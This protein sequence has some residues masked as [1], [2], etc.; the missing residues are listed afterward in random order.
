MAFIGMG[1]RDEYLVTKVIK[2][3]FL[4][5]DKKGCIYCWSNISGKLLHTT[6]L[7]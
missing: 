2:D 1:R 4:A 5:L 3:K 7:P 6:R